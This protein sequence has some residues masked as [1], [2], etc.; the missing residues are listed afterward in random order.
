MRTSW[1]GLG[2]N[3]FS[4]AFSPP[5][6]LAVSSCECAGG[7]VG[8]MV[9]AVGSPFR[10]GSATTASLTH[11]EICTFTSRCCACP[12][13]LGQPLSFAAIT[14]GIVQSNE[15]SPFTRRRVAFP[16]EAERCNGGCG[17]VES[18]EPR[19]PAWWTGICGYTCLHQASF[20]A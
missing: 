12:S 8:G 10:A 5:R 19:K 9:R 11:Y 17:E 15:E 20:L 13:R 16:S 6:C 4:F 1:F 2:A 3:F 18:H 14:H 7:W